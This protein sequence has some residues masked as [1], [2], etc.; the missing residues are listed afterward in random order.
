[1]IIRVSFAAALVACG[2]R[3]DLGTAE[4]ADATI[5]VDEDTYLDGGRDVSVDVLLCPVAPWSS[6]P[7]IPGPCPPVC[8]QTPGLTVGPITVSSP[9]CDVN[10]VLQEGERGD[11]GRPCCNDHYCQWPTPFD[12]GGL[13]IFAELGAT[14]PQ[15]IFYG[16]IDNSGVMSVCAGTT[17]VGSD[18]C[19]WATAQTITGPTPAACEDDVG[20]FTFSYEEQPVAG[21][22]CHPACTATAPIFIM[23]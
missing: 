13:Q 4:N 6:R 16:T 10:L 2:A 15:V 23:Q 22:N 5:D 9:T 21:T 7:T 3:T 12:A 8:G 20:P 14:L 17:F 11:L 18:G 19:T 1:V